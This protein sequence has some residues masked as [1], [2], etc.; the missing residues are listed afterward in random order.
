MVIMDVATGL[1]ALVGVI[2]GA[3][4]STG[5]QL[6]IASK[7]SKREADR[8]KQLVAGELLQAQLIIRAAAEGENWAL[9]RDV[10]AFLRPDE[11]AE[12]DLLN[13]P[14]KEVAESITKT[15]DDLATLTIDEPQ[16]VAWIA[17]LK[18][19][20]AKVAAY[21]PDGAAWLTEFNER[22]DTLH[23]DKSGASHL[24]GV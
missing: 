2:V 16:R 13:P 8:A 12:D 18:E 3:L 11:I 22:L 7:G 5:S 17:D 23:V 19:S 21:I 20:A 1:F 4:A 24:N 14:F 6:Y 10:D 9:F 15:L